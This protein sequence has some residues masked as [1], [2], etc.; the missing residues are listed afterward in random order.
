MGD[1]K[2][3]EKSG[4]KKEDW[5]TLVA[6]IQMLYR[7]GLKKEGIAQKLGIKESLVAWILHDNDYFRG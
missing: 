2:M 1:S 3:M 4:I 6:S 7:Q 5:E